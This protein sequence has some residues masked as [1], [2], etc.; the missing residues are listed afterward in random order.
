MSDSNYLSGSIPPAVQESRFNLILEEDPSVTPNS[1]PT[2]STVVASM[3]ASVPTEP[4]SPGILVSPSDEVDP[5]VH[6]GLVPAVVMSRGKE[7]ISH[8]SK[9][10][11]Q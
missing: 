5:P 11:K 3:S 9:P 10:A 1:P 8:V 7:P 4:V 6:K 2:T